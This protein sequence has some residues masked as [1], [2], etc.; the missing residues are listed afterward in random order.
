[1]LVE[2][3]KEPRVRL[4]GCALAWIAMAGSPAWAATASGT[5]TIGEHSLEAADAL[6]WQQPDTWGSGGQATMVLLA[7]G[8]IDRKGLDTA[9]DFEAA[10]EAVRDAA[11]SWVELEFSPEG[12]WQAVRYQFKQGG[13][14]SS[15]MKGFGA[16]ERPK[17][18]AVAVAGGNLRGTLK[19][20]EADHP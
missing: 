12:N 19:V 2:P 20:A 1:M 9:L 8:P 16:A 6:A 11:G 18:A 15:G 4:R 17:K 7:G 13:S 3:R 10:I 5:V 14:F